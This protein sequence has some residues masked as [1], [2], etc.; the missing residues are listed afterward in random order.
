MKEIPPDGLE[1]FIRS[2]KYEGLNVTIPYKEKVMPFLDHIDPE[3][4]A[5]GCVNTIVN[6]DGALYGCN[7]DFFGMTKLI[8]KAG[9]TIAGKTVAVLGTG[10]TSKTARAVAK[11]LGAADVLIVS[12]RPGEGEISYD[13]LTERRG[14]I[15][16]I[17]NTTPV[18][19]Y[20][21]EGKKP[22]DPAIFPSLS[23][24]I[25]AVY[26]PFRTELIDSAEKCGIPARSGLYMLVSQAVKA[27]EHFL[28]REYS[29]KDIDSVYAKMLRKKSNI[30]LI[31]MPGSGKSTVGRIVAERLRLDHYDSDK[32]FVERAGM[33]IPEYFAANGE[34]AFRKEE[35]KIIKELSSGHGSVISTGGGVI[36]DEGNMTALRRNGTIVFLDRPLEKL[37]GYKG[38]P[39]TPDFDSMKKKYEERYELYLRYAD[40]VIKVN[41]SPSDT[42]EKVISGTEAK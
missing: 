17:I 27:S 20:P 34:A 6:K 14:D 24:V 11:S 8:G 42:A 36:L 19:M 16:I 38:R 21:N 5:I 22:V 23:G 40:V 9:I 25:D 33:P 1:D 3:A 7:T 10:G 28:K 35:S 29:D 39:L 13:G 4:L 31:G 18:G 12:R 32:L 37:A 2:K 26:H 30:V 41:G 15:N